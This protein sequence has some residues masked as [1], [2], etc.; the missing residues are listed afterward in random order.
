MAKHFRLK[1]IR[2]ATG[3]LPRHIRTI[4]G[5]GLRGPGSEVSVADLP[6]IRGMITQVQYLLEVTPV[7]GAFVRETHP[8]RATRKEYDKKKKAK[9]KSA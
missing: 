2:S 5:L 9:K 8:K 1:Q 4:E 6:T 7:E 3:R